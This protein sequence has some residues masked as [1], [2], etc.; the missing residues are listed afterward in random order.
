LSLLLHLRELRNT[1][2]LRPATADDIRKMKMRYQK[3]YSK[4]A[5]LWVLVVFQAFTGEFRAAAQ[6]TENT[7]VG[8]RQPVESSRRK[9]PDENPRTNDGGPYGQRLRQAMQFVLDCQK[10]TD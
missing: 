5:A 8:L 4:G 3:R 9:H 6:L 1:S 2:V 7:P 10:K